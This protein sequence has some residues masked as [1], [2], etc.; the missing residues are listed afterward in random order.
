MKAALI[1]RLLVRLVRVI[2]AAI[3]KS[4]K[5]GTSQRR[6]ILMALILAGLKK[7]ESAAMRDLVDDAQ[8]M[9]GVE[10][11]LDGVLEIRRSVQ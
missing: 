1:L 6:E 5:D 2:L 11:V 9:H 3:R 8:F 10:L 7:R 4:E